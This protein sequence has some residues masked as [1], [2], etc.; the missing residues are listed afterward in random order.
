MTLVRAG[1]TAGISI[2][3][4]TVSAITTDHAAGLRKRAKLMDPTPRIDWLGAKPN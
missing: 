2:T 3:D 4:P 1:A